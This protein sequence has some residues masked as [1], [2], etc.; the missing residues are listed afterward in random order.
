MGLLVDGKWSDAWYDT[1]E[2][3]GKFVRSKSQFRNWITADGSAGPTGKPGFKAEVARY[4]L[5]VSYACPWAHRTLIV[6]AL[7]ELEKLISVSVV[8]MTMKNGGWTFNESDGSSGDALSGASHVHQIYTSADP[9]YS[10]R[11]TVPILWDKKLNTIVSNESADIIRMFNNAFDA[12]GASPGHYY[13][14]GLRQHIDT[15]NDRIYST[16]NNGVYK[17]GFATSQAAYEEALFPLFESL[18]WLE[19]ILSSRRYLTGDTLNEADIRLFT[20]LVRFDAV[21]FGHFKC[22]IRQLKDYENLWGYVRDIYQ[23]PS[24]KDTVHMDHIKVHYYASHTMINPT[25][26]VPAGPHM[27]FETPHYREQL[28]SGKAV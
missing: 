2:N 16:I 5:Y 14:E 17:A 15:L 9:A 25:G 6:R 12:L 13:P 1:K 28:M 26:I 10:G 3:G 23:I 8:G 22:N 21:Y 19:D 27:D 18:D 4:H 24:I 11:V 20:T 7:K